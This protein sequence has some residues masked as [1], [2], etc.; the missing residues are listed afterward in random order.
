MREWQEPLIACG[1]ASRAG[2]LGHA[3]FE[4]CCGRGGGRGACK[5]NHDGMIFR[6]PAMFR[7][8]CANG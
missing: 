4:S 6:W 3:R 8:V 2:N 7:V 5:G 1:S